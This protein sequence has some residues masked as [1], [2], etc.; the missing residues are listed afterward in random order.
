MKLTPESINK[1]NPGQL[2]L[3]DELGDLARKEA[4]LNAIIEA[5]RHQAEKAGIGRDRENLKSII[6]DPEYDN[7][8]SVKA[9]KEREQV[10][11]KIRSVMQSLIEAGLGELE[12]LKRQ[13]P[14][15]GLKIDR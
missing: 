2:Q 3:L 6:D 4:E 5:N 1:L 15:Y 10:K 8:I 12:I 7:L 11:E 9:I 13:A 14:N